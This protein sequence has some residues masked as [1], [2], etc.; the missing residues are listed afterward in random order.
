[1]A[2]HFKKLAIALG[3]ILVSG[4]VLAHGHHSHGV[5]MSETEQKA[6]EGMFDDDQV[7]NRALTD[8]D[9]MWQSVYP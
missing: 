2:I 3:M 5:P 6:S 1:M 9:G 7:Q 8:W 4:Q